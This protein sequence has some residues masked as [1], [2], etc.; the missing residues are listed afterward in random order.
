MDAWSGCAK[1]RPID[2]GRWVQ[3]DRGSSVHAE[4]GSSVHAVTGIVC[5][6]GDRMYT[7]LPYAGCLNSVAILW[8]LTVGAKAGC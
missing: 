5:T 6:R 2:N 8:V 3:M 1:R 4:I 7:R